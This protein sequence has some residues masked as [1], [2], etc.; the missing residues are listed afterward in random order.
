MGQAIIRFGELKVE[1][2]ETGN[3]NSWIVFSP[4]PYSKQHSSGLDGT[5]AISATP[6]V[7]II[8]ADLDVAIPPQYTYAYSIATDNKIKL[9]FDKNMYAD[10]SSALESIKCISITYELG[11]LEVNGNN[12]FLIVRN[13]LGEEIHRT[14]PQ[15]LDQTKVVI[16]TFDDTRS[17]DAGGFLKYE[18]VRDYIVK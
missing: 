7:E 3:V 15:T 16:S 18:L 4:L 12:Y 8:D 1:K 6:T 10:K 14:V 13:S 11:D 17:V 5:V 2:F 9:A